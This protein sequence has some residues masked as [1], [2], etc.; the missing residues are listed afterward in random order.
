MKWDKKRSERGKKRIT[1]KATN[2]HKLHVLSAFS[3][4]NDTS[5]NVLK[6]TQKCQAA[7][8]MKSDVIFYSLEPIQIISD[9]KGRKDTSHKY[10]SAETSTRP[11]N[12]QHVA[13]H[14]E[15]RLSTGLAITRQ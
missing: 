4:I 8:R 9:Y 15:E 14:T 11:M 13:E 5:L 1:T 7:G 2:I 12:C 3:R 10:S 6:L